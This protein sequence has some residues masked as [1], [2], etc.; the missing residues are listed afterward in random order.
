MVER[1]ATGAFGSDMAWATRWRHTICCVIAG[2][3]PLVLGLLNGKSGALY[4][5]N[6]RFGSWRFVEWTIWLV[7]ILA[8][9]DI[10]VW[11]LKRLAAEAKGNR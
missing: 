11:G 4:L 5:G 6:H 10:S 7:F 1:Q 2:F 9:V 3:A 8:L